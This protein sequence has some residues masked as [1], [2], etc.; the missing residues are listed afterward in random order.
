MKYIF[1]LNEYLEDQ[2]RGKALSERMDLKI[3][4]G[5]YKV[6]VLLK[7]PKGYEVRE[8]SIFLSN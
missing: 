6:P 2:L 1:E 3:D 8:L 4:V 7:L 5:N